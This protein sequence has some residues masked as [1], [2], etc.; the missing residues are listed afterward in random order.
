MRLVIVAQDLI[1]I[2]LLAISGE[3]ETLFP[4]ASHAHATGALAVTDVPTTRPS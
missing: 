2:V 4:V 3:T 1:R